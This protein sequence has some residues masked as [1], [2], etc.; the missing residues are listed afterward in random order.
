LQKESAAD[1]LTAGS[2]PASRSAANAAAAPPP[3]AAAP[4]RDAAVGQ[5]AGTPRAEGA[6]AKVATNRTP[7][8]F[9]REIRRLR[10][11]GRD[12][13]AA[14]ALAAF[15]AAYEDADARLPED[16]R[17]WSRSVARP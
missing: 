5:A 16:L 4:S 12:A 15:R 8:D 14:L 13:D 17:A 7:D 3:L 9:L 1:K 6:R 2:P 10:A 11:E